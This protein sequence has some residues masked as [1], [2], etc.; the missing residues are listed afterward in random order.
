M[1][2]RPAPAVHA[3]MTDRSCA[4]H[5]GSWQDMTEFASALP[6]NAHI[7]APL[8]CS[9][10]VHVCVGERLPPVSCHLCAIQAGVRRAHDSLCRLC[11][12]I[13]A[14]SS[15]CSLDPSSFVHSYMCLV[16]SVLPSLACAMKMVACVTC[17]LTLHLQDYAHLNAPRCPLRKDYSPRFPNTRPRI[18][19]V[20]G[21]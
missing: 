7:S 1:E 20:S 18:A 9:Q 3:D 2:Y 15:L 16:I 10:H 4:H 21:T 17:E 12:P 14:L 13:C 6:G 19:R 11:I 8:G 5:K